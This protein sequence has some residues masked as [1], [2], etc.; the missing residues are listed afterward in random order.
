MRFSEENQQKVLRAIDKPSPK[1]K[2]ARRINRR[3]TVAAMGILL[4]TIILFLPSMEHVIAKIPFISHFVKEEE[5]R[6]E[7]MDS[8]FKEIQLVLDEQG[9][10]I[11]AAG[12]EGKEIKVH[13]MGLTEDSKDIADQ[14][15]NRLEEVGLADYE[16]KVTAYEEGE[17]DFERHHNNK[18]IQDSIALQEALTNRLQQEGYELM[19]PVQV[20]INDVEGIYMNA[21]VPDTESRLEQLEEIMKDEAK[22]YGEEYKL[23]IR[24]VEK[25]AREQE[26]RWEKTGALRHISSALMEAEKYPV[27]G[28]AHSFHPYPLQIKVKTS[29]E[30]NDPQTSEIAME[31]LNEIE[32]YIQ[33]DEGTKSIRDDLYEVKVLSKD[34]KEIKVK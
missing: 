30:V 12:M 24:Q 25:V 6:M 2:S 27:T 26:L 33:T 1:N 17:M 29:L 7:E 31:I 32:L 23:S 3:L 21:I 5:Q 10:E 18:D 22:V 16:V 15:H 13:I 14:I 34:K 11:G 9:M 19:F 20:R 8:I 4:F 28:F